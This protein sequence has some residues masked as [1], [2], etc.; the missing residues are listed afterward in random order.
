MGRGRK[1][2]LEQ[3]LKKP[4]QKPTVSKPMPLMVCG[5]NLNEQIRPLTPNEI[6]IAER[7]SPPELV[8]LLLGGNTSAGRDDGFKRN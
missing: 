1:G 3:S 2:F 7:F 4:K 6:K 8:K 5:L